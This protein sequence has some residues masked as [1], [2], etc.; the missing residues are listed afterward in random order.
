MGI[1]LVRFTSKELRWENLRLMDTGA[2]Q[3]TL[4]TLAIANESDEAFKLRFTL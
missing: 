2:N 1:G 3:T 4:A